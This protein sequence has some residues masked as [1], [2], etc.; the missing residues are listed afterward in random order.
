[1]TFPTTSDQTSDKYFE[2]C[3]FYRVIPEHC[4]IFLHDQEKLKALVKKYPGYVS[5][6]STEM[7][8]EGKFF[9]AETLIRFDTLET[10]FSGLIVQKEGN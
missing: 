9:V 4:Q 7:R 3:F 1:M 10:L 6:D 5:E 8:L 2:Y